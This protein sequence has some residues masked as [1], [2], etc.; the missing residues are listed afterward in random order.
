MRKAFIM[1]SLLIIMPAAIFAQEWDG[2]LPKLDKESADTVVAKEDGVF[3]PRPEIK[4]SAF[5]MERLL[6]LARYVH[7]NKPDGI[8]HGHIFMVHRFEVA[9]DNLADGSF[10]LKSIILTWNNG[11][12]YELFTLYPDGTADNKV[13]IGYGRSTYLDKI[14][15]GT[16]MEEVALWV[17]YET[18]RGRYPPNPRPKQAMTVMQSSDSESVYARRERLLAERENILD[19]LMYA[20]REFGWAED[21]DSEA[22]QIASIYEHYGDP[23]S[24]EAVEARRAADTASEEREWS[25]EAVEELENE[26]DRVEEALRKLN[27]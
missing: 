18:K 13:G 10:R 6:N 14:K 23:D 15:V 5:Q 26:L 11:F 12:F 1:L 2:K 27:Q 9:G 17:D 16:L 3:P 4:L 25:K 19:K 7:D 21:G 8:Q 20:R 24:D 22:E